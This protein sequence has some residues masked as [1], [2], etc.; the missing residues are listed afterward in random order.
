MLARHIRIAG[1]LRAPDCTWSGQS[2]ATRHAD[3]SF[4]LVFLHHAVVF[5]GQHGG[6]QGVYFV[7]A[8]SDYGE[9][10]GRHFALTFEIVDRST[11][12]TTPF[13]VPVAPRNVSR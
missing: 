1:L 6:S 4:F 2:N 8:A 10:V 13:Q 11:R 7:G 5:P 12:T 9:M 3:Y